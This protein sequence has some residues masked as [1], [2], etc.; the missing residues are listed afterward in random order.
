MDGENKVYQAGT[1]IFKQ[2]EKGGSFLIIESGSVEVYKE[3]AKGEVP[4]VCLGEGEILGL[5]TFYDESPRMASARAR[6]DVE[7]KMVF[8]SKETKEKLPPW[9]PVVL[10]ECALRLNQVNDLYTRSVQTNKDLSGQVLDPLFM[11]S[12]IS[13]LICEV[14][15]YHTIKIA[16]GREMVLLSDMVDMAEEIFGYKRRDIDQ[17]INVFTHFGLMKKEMEPDRHREV[18]AVKGAKKLKWF[19]EFA[20][21]SR[22]GKVRRLVDSYIPF[23]NRKV[24]FALRDYAANTGRSTTETLT[25]PLREVSEKFEELTK[26]PF[27]G[28]AIKQANELNLLEIKQKG[29]E[30]LL[31]YHPMNLART[32]I[33]LNVINQLRKHPDAQDIPQKKNSKSAS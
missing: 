16:D 27:D 30:T 5:L 24:L 20:R 28:T 23:K 26:I 15:K 8:K 13:A 7:G 32:V 6:T 11:A 33:S 21:M 12:Q 25:I 2:G 10:K 3:S 9:V 22:S 14:G 4:L 1:T 17:I 29:E 31:V 19:S 18:V